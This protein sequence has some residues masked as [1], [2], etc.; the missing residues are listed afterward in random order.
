MMEEGTTGSTAGERTRLLVDHTYT[1]IH[2]RTYMYNT[3]LLLP[4]LL[5][6]RESARARTYRAYIDTTTLRRRRGK[7][8]HR[9][10]REP[11]RHQALRA[12]SLSRQLAPVLHGRRTCPRIPLGER[13]LSRLVAKLRFGEIGGESALPRSLSLP[14]SRPL[15]LLVSP[16]AVAMLRARSRS[17]T[18]HPLSPSLPSSPTPDPPLHLPHSISFTLVYP[19]FVSRSSS[20]A[21]A[22]H[23]PSLHHH[24][25]SFQSPPL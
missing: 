6:D 21:R 12:S 16:A 11:R 20:R 22:H 10:K 2:T 15:C 23:P 17:R 1:H 18:T 14:L 25:L 9:E 4:C 8:K 13:G 3:P 19:L 5:G 7:K 24:P